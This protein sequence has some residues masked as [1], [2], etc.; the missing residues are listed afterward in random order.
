MRFPFSRRSRQFD[1]FDCCVVVVVAVCVCVCV[2]VV[3]GLAP[4]CQ[5]SQ[6][7]F[8]IDGEFEIVGD[9]LFFSPSLFAVFPACG[10]ALASQH[11]A[12]PVDPCYSAAVGID[13]RGLEQ[14]S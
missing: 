10:G 5:R 3:N 1:S 2:L 6:A 4:G 14:V 13:I 7:G 11:V 8:R 12:I 9:G